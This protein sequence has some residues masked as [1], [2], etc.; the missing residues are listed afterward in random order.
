MK[1][2]R[3]PQIPWPSAAS[4]VRALGEAGDAKTIDTLLPL[5][6]AGEPKDV[7]LAA[8]AA[9]WGGSTTRASRRPCS[10]RTRTCRP[11]CGRA[12]RRCSSG[13]PRWSRALVDAVDAG[14]VAPDL[15]PPDA[16]RRLLLHRDPRLDARGGE[17]LGLGP[18]RQRRGEGR[19]DRPRAPGAGR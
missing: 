6:A 11:T 14:R 15:V 2:I 4:L 10:S 5:V 3:D 9:R 16:A 1:Q 12:R 7:R 18:P 13:G 17:V 19:L 8:L